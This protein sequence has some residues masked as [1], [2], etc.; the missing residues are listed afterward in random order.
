MQPYQKVLLLL[1]MIFISTS[2]QSQPSFDKEGHRGCRGLLPENS[3]PAMKKAIDLGATLEMDISFSEDK[4]PIISHDQHINSSIALKPNGDTISKEEEKLLVLYQ[5]NY[6]TIRKYICGQKYYPLFPQ[7]QLVKTCIPTLA[8]LIDSVETYAKRY[9][10]PLPQ[11]NIETKT[12]PAGDNK[13]HPAP[14]EFVERMMKVVLSKKI[15]KRV[16]IQSFDPRTLEIIHQKYP[17]I[18]TLYLVQA[19]DLKENLSKLSFTP[20]I[21]SPAFKLVNEQLVRDCHALKIKII[22]WTV[23][24]EADI[25]KLKAWGVDG[26]ISDYPNLL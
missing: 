18:P 1:I 24:T 13:L 9:H 22:P 17:E 25:K 20:S 12:T 14:E 26:I 19:K 11:Y 21:Y 2:A 3:I 6:A 16:I 15:V 7:Q 4:V 23:D 8:E 10:K 5:M